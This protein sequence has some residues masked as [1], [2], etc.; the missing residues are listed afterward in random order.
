MQHTLLQK[1]QNIRAFFL[2]VDGVLTD[3]G[4]YL[5]PQGDELKRFH[6]HDGLGLKQLQQHQIHIAVISGRNSKTVTH[7]MRELNIPHV[8]QGISSKLT[9]YQQLLRELQLTDDVIAYM[10]DDLPDL[11]VLTRVGFSIAPANAVA[12]VKQQVD[13]VTHRDG[14]NA[15]VREACE[16]ILFAKSSNSPSSL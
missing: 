16:F 7:R 3:G 14:G 1:A 9:A 10:G 15:A 4:F 5:T 2:D 6:T 13:W 11:P 8:Y 12:S